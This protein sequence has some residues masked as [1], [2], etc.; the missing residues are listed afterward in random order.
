MKKELILVV[1]AILFIVVAIYTIGKISRLPLSNA[2]KQVLYWITLF[3][4]LL[5]L[6]VTWHLQKRT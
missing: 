3:V 1:A 4:P 5:G 6:L 2:R